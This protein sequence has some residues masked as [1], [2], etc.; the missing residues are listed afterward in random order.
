[1]TTQLPKVL[2][3][4]ASTGIGATYA[5][6]FA[7]RGHDLVLVARDESRMRALAEPSAAGNFRRD[8]D[9]QS[10][11]DLAGRPRA[12]RVAAAR[13][14]AHRRARQQRRHRSA[15]QLCEPGS[16]SHREP[17]AAQRYRA[18]APDRG[19]GAALPATRRRRDRQYRLGTSR[20]RPSSRWAHTEQRSRMSWRSRRTCKASSAR[21][22]STCKQCC[23]PLRERRSGSAPAVTWRR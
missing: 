10:R 17:A 6:R 9:R 5:D 19:R 21:G 14:R 18:D 13:R 22:A 11:P 23:P 8:R 20:S 12:R 15:W 7:R 16:R 1:M 4:G 3:T 2:I